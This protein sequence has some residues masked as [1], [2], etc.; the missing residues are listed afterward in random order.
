MQD[1]EKSFSSF[2][3]HALGMQ[4]YGYQQV[5]CLVFSNRTNQHYCRPTVW[6][7]RVISWNC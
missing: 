5:H 1:L 6:W 7:S 2:M 4:P 3:S